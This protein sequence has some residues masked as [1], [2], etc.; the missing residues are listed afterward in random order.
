MLRSFENVSL[1]Q[2]RKLDLSGNFLTK[3]LAGSVPPVESIGGIA[4]LF[5]QAVNVL[6][7]IF[8]F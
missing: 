1:P 7:L 5:A 3:G 2:W 6:T 4:S 8:A